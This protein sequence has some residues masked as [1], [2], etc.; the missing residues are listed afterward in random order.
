M[1]RI[2]FTDADLARVKVMGRPDP[3]WEIYFSLR[4]F[5]SRRGLWSYADWHRTARA[6]LHDKGLAPTV[7][8]V[9]LPLYPRGA[10]FPDFLTPGESSE[11][12][13]AGLDSILGIPRR[14]VLREI[15]LLDRVSGAPAWS[16]GLADSREREE[17]VRTVR[18][19]YDVALRPHGEHIQAHVDADRSVRARALLE[20]GVHG[21]LAG[22]GPSMR[23]QPPTLSVEYAAEDRDLYLRGRGLT[24][25]P[26]YFCWGAP[27]SLADSALPPVLAYPLRH[28]AP[29]AADAD[30]RQ[31]RAPLSALLGATRAVIL[32]ATATGATT[33][34]L[35]RAAGVSAAAATRHTTVLRDAG[36]ILS[37]RRGQ[38]VLHT[39]A[40]A[41][42]ALLRTGAHSPRTDPFRPTG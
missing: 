23:W 37:H 14:R 24:L 29:R 31:A 30:A 32:Q 39:L 28:R 2:H 12:L 22:L 13:E 36:L 20:G 27:V 26:S 5:Q 25:V 4:R 9:L 38:S 33:G 34:E 6:D 10:Y 1:L 41:G 7:R 8:N 42:A 15:A 3:L 16:R 18:T 19:Y 35:A 40:P 17:F 11:G 21:L